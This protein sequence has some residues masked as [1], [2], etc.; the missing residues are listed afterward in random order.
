[1][2]QMDSNLLPLA[3]FDASHGQ[4]NWMQTGFTSREMHTNFA[5]LMEILCRAGFQCFSTGEES[6][7]SHLHGCQ[8]LIVPTPTGSYQSAKEV[9]RKERCALFTAEEISGI[10]NFLRC[11]GRLMTFAYRFGDSFT[12]TNLSALFAPLGCQLND[13]AVIDAGAVREIHPLQMHF[14]ISSDRLPLRWS[15]AN[16]RTVR[17][18]PCATFRILPEAAA[19]PLALSPGGSCLSFDRRLKRISFESLPIAV[20]GNYGRG[21]FALFGGPH[22]FETSP[23]GLLIEADN[24]RFLQNIIHWLLEEASEGEMADSCD[25]SFLSTGRRQFT[26]VESCGEGART[27]RSVER[28]LRR[29]GILKAL[30]RARWIP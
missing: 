27:I 14:D 22:I 12:K 9:W 10:L 13:D 11:G 26:C 17:S 28:V 5:G 4:A 24:A 21:K 29:A 8:F 7:R 3:L 2:G 30:S 6:L 23:L 20:A 16:V 25:N 1:M 19:W 15:R 18:R